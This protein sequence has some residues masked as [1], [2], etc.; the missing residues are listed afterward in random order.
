MEILT[1]PSNPLLP[2]QSVSLW[3][4]AGREK[5]SRAELLAAD[6]RA[7]ECSDSRWCE[8]AL[9]QEQKTCVTLIFAE[10]VQELTIGALEAGTIPERILIYRKG[11]AVPDS[12]LGPEETCFFPENAE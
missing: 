4:S 9:S 2:G 11:T 3:V 10:G 1:A 12:Y 6:Y 5:G 8:A 7:G